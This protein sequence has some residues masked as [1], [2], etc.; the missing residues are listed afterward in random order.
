MSKTPITWL[1]LINKKLSELKKA[2]KT[3][4]IRD[5]APEAKAE[6]TKI[7]AGTHPDY[8]QGKAKAH[9][10]KKKSEK[11]EKD[12]DTDEEEEHKEMK[13]LLSTI[14]LC[15]KC[16]KELNK[17]MKKQKGGA[18]TG[19]G[20]G[21]GA[22]S[23]NCNLYQLNGPQPLVKEGPIPQ[24]GILNSN[25]VALSDA[26]TSMKNAAPVQ[27]GGNCGCSLTGG[28]KSK[29]NRH[30]KKNKKYSKKNKH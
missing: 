14:K 28:K 24:S 19:A 8:V 23:G 7:K 13:K 25:D 6:W 11:K 20:A 26:S 17:A 30:N 15:G 27:N 5:V 9:A 22:D 10:R 12:T 3:A 21:A 4:S 29:K 18:G 1:E 16:S 2:G